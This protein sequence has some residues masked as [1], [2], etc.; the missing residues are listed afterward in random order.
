[1]SIRFTDLGPP[2]TG[3]LAVDNYLLSTTKSGRRPKTI[4]SGT[5]CR[6]LNA[7][8]LHCQRLAVSLLKNGNCEVVDNE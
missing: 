5:G 4:V 8:I 6:Q 2:Q 3:W 1:M 7:K